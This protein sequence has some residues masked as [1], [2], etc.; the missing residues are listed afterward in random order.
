MVQQMHFLSAKSYTV[1]YPAKEEKK[2]STNKTT[3]LALAL[4][5]LATL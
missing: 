1:Y 3:N 2:L 5:C 4:L